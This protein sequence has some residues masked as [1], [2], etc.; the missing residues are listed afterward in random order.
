MTIRELVEKL[1]LKVF[2]GEKGLDKLVKSAYCSDLLSDVM[3][4]GDEDQLW[5][6]LQTHKNAMAVA[7]L[8]DMSGILLVNNHKANA[9]TVEASNE[10]GIPVLG[11]DKPAF[12]L[13]GLIYQLMQ[14]S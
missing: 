2:S 12:E 6:T 7:A 11:S 8:K 13:C 14:E 9:D 10:E 1:E 5:I 4:N 3:G